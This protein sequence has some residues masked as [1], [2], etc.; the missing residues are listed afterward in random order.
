VKLRIIVLGA[1][2]GGLELSTILSDEIGENLDLT[3]IDKNDTFFF[4]Y[5]KL[6]VMF[7]RKTPDEVRLPYSKIV[8][9]GVHFRQESNTSI[10]PVNRRVTT[11]N[12]T[13]EADVLV[14]ALGADYDPDA[15]PGL[16]MGGN[17]YYS[18]AG[19]ERLREVLPT[20]KKGRAIVGVTS[21]PFKCPPAP[22]EAALLLHDYLTTRGVREACKIS[23]VMPFGVPIPP[24]PASSKA[25]LRAFDERGSLS[26][27][28]ISCVPWNQ[29]EGWSFLTTRVSC[30]MT[31]FSA[32]RS[33]AS[34]TW[35]QRAVWQRTAGFRSTRR[36]SKRA[37]PAYTPSEM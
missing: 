30:L 25:L 13:Y 26:S 15:T 35:L 10:D 33:T 17:E 8:K 5:S 11:D 19:A 6:D 18:F 34:Q 12:G 37:T 1:G 7:G 14:V 29:G 32:S 2:F 23:L 21:V 36:T 16:V 20:F 3:L 24:A 22:S 28:N 4:G 31:Y 9:P 27:P